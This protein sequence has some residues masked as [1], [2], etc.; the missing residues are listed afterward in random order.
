VSKPDTTDGG[1]ERRN[2]SVKRLPAEPQ[3][4]GHQMTDPDLETPQEECLRKAD[5]II[6]ASVNA[7]R[8]FVTEDVMLLHWRVHRSLRLGISEALENANAK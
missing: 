6:A 8:E 3:S 7:A 5:E 2:V 1:A 4:D